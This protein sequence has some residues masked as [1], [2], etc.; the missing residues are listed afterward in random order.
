MRNTRRWSTPATMGAGLFV[1]TTGLLMFFVAEVPFKFAHELAGLA[2]VGAAVLHIVSNWR[3]FRNYF[4]QR[5]GLGV[6]VLLWSMGTAAVVASSVLEIGE[7][8][9]LVV[10]SITN[11]QIA[12]LAPVVGR[13][14][15]E[16][17]DRLAADGFEVED[18]GLSV[19]EVALQSGADPDDVL[20]SV[21]R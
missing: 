10:T 20:F 15:S 3:P 4:S 21:F 8:D 13:E 12:L 6:F 18:P 1:M 9:T 5:T 7:A 14:V 2:F 17:V 19:E 16:L 11:T